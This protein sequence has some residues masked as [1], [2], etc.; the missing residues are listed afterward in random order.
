[1]QRFTLFLGLTTARRRMPRAIGMTVLAI[2]FCAPLLAVSG[3]HDVKGAAYGTAGQLN[4][5]QKRDKEATE[6]LNSGSRN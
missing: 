3:C 1:M 6:I 2:A 4:E 5:R